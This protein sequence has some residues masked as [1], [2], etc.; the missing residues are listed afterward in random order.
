MEDQHLVAFVCRRDSWLVRQPL[1]VPMEASSQ[2]PRWRLSLGLTVL[3][4]PP[5]P[6]GYVPR[7]RKGDHQWTPS[8]DSGEEDDE[9]PDWFFIFA[10][11]SCVL[12]AR[13]DLYFIYPLDSCM[14]I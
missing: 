3:F 10:L 6:N 11:E 1:L 12:N 5:L 13:T 9:G 8:C 2:P 14:Q 4:P 7:E